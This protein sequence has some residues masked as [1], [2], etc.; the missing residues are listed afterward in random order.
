MGSWWEV[1]NDH[2]GRFR[3]RSQAGERLADRL[4]HYGGHDILILGIPRGGVPVAA[5][6]AGRLAAELDIVVARKL[7]AP[8]WPELAIG[9]VT[10]N[11][12]RFLN[13]AIVRELG[14]QPAYLEKVTADEQAEARRREERLR[15]GLPVRPI[16]GRVVIIVDDGLATG[17]TM[18]GPAGGGGAGRLAR[19]LRCLASRGGRGDLPGHARNL[20]GGWRLL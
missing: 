14:V 9:A 20:L 13:Q 10:A 19:G 17:S 1:N 2:D 16:Q 8:G 15:G 7:G 3:D 6:V 18:R 12:G 4:A 11:G 5:A